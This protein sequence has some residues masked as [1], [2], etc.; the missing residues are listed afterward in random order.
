MLIGA[1]MFIAEKTLI[2]VD[3]LLTAC[4]FTPDD[5]PRLEQK[6]FILSII[7]RG[8]S[9]ILLHALSKDACVLSILREHL[10]IALNTQ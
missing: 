4:P 1:G 7:L 10:T 2:Q 9:I 3:R 6:R 8:S 5:C